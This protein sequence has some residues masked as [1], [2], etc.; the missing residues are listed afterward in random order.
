MMTLTVPRKCGLFLNN[1]DVIRAQIKTAEILGI[2][3]TIQKTL[4]NRKKSTNGD[5]Y[6]LSRLKLMCMSAADIQVE[7]LTVITHGAPSY[8]VFFNAPNI[9][10]FFR[11]TRA[12]FYNLI[13]YIYAIVL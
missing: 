2:T 11:Q 4:N 12:R 3:S 13:V 7:G 10:L 1:Y 6:H 8:A 5:Y 9:F